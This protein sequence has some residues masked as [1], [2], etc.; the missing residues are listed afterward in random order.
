MNVVFQGYVKITTLPLPAPGSG[1]TRLIT[2]TGS[3]V[4][5]SCSPSPADSPSD[6]N[7]PTFPPDS[8]R[9]ENEGQ[10]G[11]PA[12]PPRRLPRQPLNKLQSRERLFEVGPPK[13]THLRGKQQPATCKMKKGLS[14]ANVSSPRKLLLRTSTDTQLLNPLHTSFIPGKPLK[15]IEESVT[16]VKLTV[17]KLRED[18]IRSSAERIQSPRPNKRRCPSDETPTI[19]S[20]APTHV[21]GNLDPV[22]PESPKNGN[23]GHYLST[24]GQT[25]F[26]KSRS[27][28]LCKRYGLIYAGNM[29]WFHGKLSRH[30]A[31]SRLL[32]VSKSQATIG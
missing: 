29:A 14:E 30:K 13:V 20:S 21:Q 8:K 24:L 2:S 7:L 10:S 26:V 27:V 5:N 31:E 32:K 6:E 3:S 18:Q 9:R 22:Q 28:M 19:P 12:I 1:S 23:A 15:I 11:I 25:N 16:P 4:E 17:E